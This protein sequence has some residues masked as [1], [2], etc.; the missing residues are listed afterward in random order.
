MNANEV[1]L[2]LVVEWRFPPQS[3]LQEVIDNMQLQPGQRPGM[4]SLMKSRIKMWRGC[5]RHS[6]RQMIGKVRL[7][8]FIIDYYRL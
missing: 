4:E 5:H 3:A 2:M 7:L 6:I 1:A 8:S